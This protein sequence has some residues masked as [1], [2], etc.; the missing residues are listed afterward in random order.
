MG[1]VMLDK[2]LNIPVQAKDF[3]NEIQ[4]LDYLQF[5]LHMLALKVREFEEPIREREIL[6]NTNIS[7]FGHDPDVDSRVLRLLPCLFHWYGVS[8]CNY[9][10]LVG[11]VLGMSSKKLDAQMLQ[12]KMG[13]EIIKGYCD[14]YVKSVTEIAEVLKWRNK[15]GAHFAITDPRKV[16]NIATLEMSVMF[17][18]GYA[19]GS[20]R[21]N[22]M[23]LSKTDDAGTP[24]VA[25]LP[26]WSVT[27][28]HQK[29]IPRFWNQFGFPTKSGP[30][31]DRN[32]R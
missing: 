15:V 23:T 21:V 14:D 5:G 29:L 7:F 10:R 18:I 11:F 25:D 24:Q 1:L 13:G 26:C 22:V 3:P 28:V 30:P 8:L 19:N 4:T 20:F 32:R 12:T 31:V 2:L 9:A 6:T 17:P 16:D 27:E